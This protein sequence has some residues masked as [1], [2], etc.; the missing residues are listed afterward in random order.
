MEIARRF[1]APQFIYRAAPSLRKAQ[2]KSHASLPLVS[3]L[4]AQAEGSLGSKTKWEKNLRLEWFSWPPGRK[5]KQ[6]S[7]RTLL[8]FQSSVWFLSCDPSCL[9]VLLLCRTAACGSVLPNAPAVQAVCRGGFP[10]EPAGGDDAEPG[11]LAASGDSP[12]PVL[13]PVLEGSAA[14]YGRGC[15]TFCL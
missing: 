4:L 2:Q 3:L 13:F 8:G 7:D 9:K 5:L 11:E 14:S 10:A 1:A 6:D 15:V 12:E